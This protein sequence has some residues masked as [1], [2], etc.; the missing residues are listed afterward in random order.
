MSFE[1]NE[2]RISSARLE[3]EAK[4]A[5]ITL[6][7]YKEKIAELQ[8]DIEDQKTEIENLKHTQIREKEEEKEKRKQEMLNEMMS[9]IDLGGTLDSSSE[10]LRAVLREFEE[11]SDA[12][13][14]EK[15][16]SQTREL[17]RT[18]L[19]ESQD[20]MRGLQERL[21][22]AGEEQD[23]QV[24]RRSELEKMLEKRDAAFDELLG[25]CMGACLKYTLTVNAEKTASGQGLSFAEIKSS[26]ETKYSSREELLR[27]EISTLSDHVE[28]RAQD[29]RR[30]QSTVES[31]KLSN[32]ELNRAL[33]A[34]TIGTDGE[35]FASS[36][37]ELERARKA[38]E[39]QYAEFEMVKKSL[40]KDLQ[41][42]C[43]KASPY[44]PFVATAVLTK[45]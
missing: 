28:S 6:D 16:T 21:R 39:I 5:T 14:K 10:K 27:T 24:K 8:K 44:F 34:A 38:H 33:T 17:I 32:E 3:S 23:M 2:L 43:E 13:R 30:L 9:K 36:A 42:R 29:V 26:L 22:L 7:S 31:Y 11:T 15:L 35:T 41:N 45:L 1:L 20:A 18:S 40:M 37:K 19:A 12:E 4:D 25:E